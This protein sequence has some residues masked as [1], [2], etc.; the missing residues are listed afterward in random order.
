MKLHTPH[1][2]RQVPADRNLALR[3]ESQVDVRGRSPVPGNWTTYDRQLSAKMTDAL[4][5]F[6]RKGD[7]TTA[8]VTWPA[9][10]RPAPVAR[11]ETELRQRECDDR[12]RTASVA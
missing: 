2:V 9:W 1:A 11:P 6:A 5:V 12:V 4:I 10:T 7:P 8:A 3:E